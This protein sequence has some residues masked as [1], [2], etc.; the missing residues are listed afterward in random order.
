[1]SEEVKEE[2]EERSGGGREKKKRAVTSEIDL[3]VALEKR[4]SLLDSS[5][6]ICKSASREIEPSAVREIEGEAASGEREENEERCRSMMM[7]KPPS[8][9]VAA[10]DGILSSFEQTGLSPLHFDLSTS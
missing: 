7:E 10:V 3:S 6:R 4:P 2:E 8:T 1:M 5:S 9:S